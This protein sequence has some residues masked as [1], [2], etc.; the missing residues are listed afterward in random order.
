MSDELSTIEKDV[1]EFLVDL[2]TERIMLMYTGVQ[3]SS[4]RGFP[5]SPSTAR[6]F[7]PS[8]PSDEKR[9]KHQDD[10]ANSKL[11][12]NILTSYIS[13][14]SGAVNRDSMPKDF[15]YTLVMAYLPKGILAV[16]ANQDKIAALKFSNFNLGDRKVYNMLAPHKYLTRT[17]GNNS[18]IIPQS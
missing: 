7:E 12:L 2:M 4:M 1:E 14:L 8:R 10:L 5:T 11:I 13:P 3:A 6:G 9:T 16:R 15:E 18:K 17:K